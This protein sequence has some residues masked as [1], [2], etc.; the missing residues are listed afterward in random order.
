LDKQRLRG[1]RG[2]GRGIVVQ[3]LGR[4]QDQQ[5]R[6]STSCGAMIRRAAAGLAARL[7]RAGRRPDWPT[8]LAGW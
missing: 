2:G 6:W 8:S 1:A 5:H 7:N 3:R 4:G